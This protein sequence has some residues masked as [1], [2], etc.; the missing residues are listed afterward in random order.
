MHG[1]GFIN[2]P[3][4]PGTHVIE[5]Q[6]WKPTIDLKTRISEFFLG[7]LIRAKNIEEISKF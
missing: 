2:I 4:F 5:T 6:T 3:A 7:G 1:C